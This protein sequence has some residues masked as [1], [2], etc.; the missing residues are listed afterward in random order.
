MSLMDNVQQKTKHTFKLAQCLVEVLYISNW[1]VV[2]S[3]LN[4]LRWNYCRSL[5]GVT[6]VPDAE[7]AEAAVQVALFLRQ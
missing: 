5:V 1:T 2:V 7:D 6:A 3:K 4:F